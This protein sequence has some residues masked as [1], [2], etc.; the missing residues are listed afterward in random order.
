MNKVD[1]FVIT[2]E[3]DTERRSG[4]AVEGDFFTSLKSSFY[5]LASPPIEELR[6][7]CDVMECL[8]AIFVALTGVFSPFRWYCRL[9][10]VRL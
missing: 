5:A 4:K 2:G 8:Q 9:L 10:Q 6:R 7:A 3:G 1:A